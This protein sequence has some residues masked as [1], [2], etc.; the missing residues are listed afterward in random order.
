MPFNARVI[1]IYTFRFVLLSG[2]LYLPRL[3]LGSPT[4]L[5]EN[6]LASNKDMKYFPAF[7]FNEPFRE[8]AAKLQ[9]HSQSRETKVNQ[10]SI[11]YNANSSAILKRKSIPFLSFWQSTRISSYLCSLSLP[12]SSQNQD[13]EVD[14][15]PQGLSW[16]IQLHSTGNRNLLWRWGG[17]GGGQKKD[18]DT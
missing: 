11:S 15:S 7:I 9:F 4:V 17:G 12:P 1:V 13:K 2:R 10:E 3:H 14:K 5:T 6:I 18:T 8:K 16:A